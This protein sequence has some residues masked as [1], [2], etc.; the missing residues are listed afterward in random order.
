MKNVTEFV[1]QVRAELSKVVWPKRAEL[2]G[3]V[4]VVL[5]LVVAFSL[6]LGVVDMCL[7]WAAQW[8]FVRYGM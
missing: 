2:M 3:S 1:G 5:V 4:L 6:Y 7:S 8:I